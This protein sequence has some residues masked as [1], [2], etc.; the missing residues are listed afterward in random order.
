MKDQL[1]NE[2]KQYLQIINDYHTKCHEEEKLDLATYLCE[3]TGGYDKEILSSLVEKG[4]IERPR[5][6]YQKEGK[7]NILSCI[8]EL[9][10]KGKK[11]IESSGN[12]CS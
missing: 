12:I 2:E 1:N 9:T 8:S 6:I 11:W 5:R 4:Y 10:L 3:K 7:K